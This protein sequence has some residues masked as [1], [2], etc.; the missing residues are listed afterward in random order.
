MRAPQ[1]VG[2]RRG[3]LPALEQNILKFRAYQMILTMFYAEELKREI[4]YPIQRR[5]AAGDG[6]STKPQR[7][8]KHALDFLENDGIFA[9]DERAEIFKLLNYR[10]TIAHQIHDLTADLSNTRFVHDRARYQTDQPRFDYQAL[11]RL[12]YFRKLLPKRLQARGRVVT[13]GSSD[14]V[15]EAANRT[16]TQELNRLERRIIALMRKRKH[17]IEEVNAELSL[18]GTELQDDLHPLN[19]LNR[20][21]DGRLTERGAE[22]IYRLFD[23]G[24]SPMAAAYLMDLSI[25]AAK[26]RLKLW[27]AAGGK[28]RTTC[29]IQGLPR[30]RFYIRDE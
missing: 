2:P 13:V 28:D 29:D 26:N 15:F 19:S 8:M 20:Y 16:Y 22:T 3:R 1:Y 18:E 4:Q 25:A 5:D 21:D 6:A 14:I 9:A 11:E 24:K 12:R 17:E 27:H 30:R 10:N 7:S 23:M